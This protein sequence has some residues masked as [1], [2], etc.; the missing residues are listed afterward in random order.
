VRLALLMRGEV[1]RPHA[2]VST[3]MRAQHSEVRSRRTGTP[4]SRPAPTDCQTSCCYDCYSI[5][6]VMSNQSSI[7]NPPAVSTVSTSKRFPWS[8]AVSACW[9]TLEP[10][11]VC[12]T[13]AYSEAT[14]PASDSVFSI[15][16]SFKHKSVLSSDELV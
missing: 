4:P 11:Y 15:A 1:E 7:R 13:H 16:A 3:A 12:A 10:G 8:H 5:M 2:G 6:L 14:P 9:S